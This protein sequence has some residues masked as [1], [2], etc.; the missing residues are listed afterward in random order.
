M[1]IVRPSSAGRWVN[2]AGS[3]QME[4]NVPEG[5]ESDAAKEGTAA[6]WVA[7]MVLTNQVGCA[8]DL[9]DRQA[10]NNVIVDP[11]MARH[12]QGYVDRI[13]RRGLVFEAEKPFQYQLTDQ[14]M[15]QGTADCVSFDADT[16]I[17]HVDDLKYGWR[18]VQV[19]GNWQL[20]AYAIGAYEWLKQT[21]VQRIFVTIE[22]PRPYHM[23]GTV[24]TWEIPIA[25]IDAYKNVLAQK[26][27][28]ALQPDAMCQTGEHCHYCDAL[29][30][31]PAAQQAGMN[32]VDVAHKAM[33]DHLTPEA[34]SM[35][36]DN[37]DR[38]KK[39]LEA[40]MD[41]LHDLAKN[42]IKSGKSIPGWGMQ[43][44][45]GKAKWKEGVDLNTMG[46]M[47]GKDLSNKKPITP[48]EAVRRGI[49]KEFV[50]ASKEIPETSPKLVRVD[51]DQTAQ[52]MFSKG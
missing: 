8:E 5:L 32:A 43:R 49:P 35:E 18:A 3:I 9:V 52:S 36:L 1:I 31:C 15:V 42:N 4:S 46:M 38:A 23:Q 21:G 47:F 45:V 12:S 41:Q 20:I 14:I 16:G 29:V 28:E 34:M 11:D 2:C 40:R 17:L 26:A 48:A 25:M 13:R 30:F 50:D 22:Q 39:M 7:E 10:P 27:T 24:R 44:G 6:H 37:L 19:D 51:D 33:S